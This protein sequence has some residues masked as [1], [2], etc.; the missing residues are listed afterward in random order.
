M[1]HAWIMAAALAA[2]VPG[3]ACADQSAN[4]PDTPRLT[5]RRPQVVRSRSSIAV[6]SKGR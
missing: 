3:A 2:L 4:R 1:K 5:T 6:F